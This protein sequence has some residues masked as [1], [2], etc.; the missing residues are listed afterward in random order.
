MRLN[1]ATTDKIIRICLFQCNNIF[2]STFTRDF[3][4][5]IM[6]NGAMRLL[7]I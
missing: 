5:L 2:N 1:L 6:N 7:L 3:Y 4:N